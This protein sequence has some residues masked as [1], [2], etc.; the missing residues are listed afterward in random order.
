LQ[1]EYILI[2]GYPGKE[3]LHKH[4]GGGQLTAS[5]LLVEYAAENDLE[6]HVVNTAHTVFPSPTFKEKIVES[7]KRIGTLL[8][9]LKNKNI[10]G[11]IIFSSTG[12]SFYEKI[13]MAWIIEKRKI[14]TLFF[15]RSGH[16]IDLNEQ[17]MV[18]SFINKKLLKIPSYL[19][20]QGTKWIEF[21]KTMD[22]EESKLKLIPNWIRIKYDTT[23]NTND[24]K[25]TFL[26]VGWTVKK[27]GILEVFDVIEE[28][29]DLNDYKFIFAG[30]G[31]LL[32]ELKERKIKNKLDNI[33]M[34][35]WVKPKDLPTL[36]NDSDVFILPSHAEG[37]PNVI[38]EA[39]NYGLPIISTNVGGIADSVID[40]DNGF[41]FEPR[42]KEKLYESIKSLGSSAK[43][44]ET[45]SKNG[46]R[47]L[48][49]RHE[50]YKNCQMIFDS[51]EEKR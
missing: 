2:G 11:V 47:I 22:I 28:H 42:D 40:N 20:A 30:G 51:F 41:I 3:N 34:L 14:K 49:E 36:Y 35:G 45:F 13:V 19:G 44:R 24:E 39:L 12:L 31:T 7:K 8:K 9:L 27:K 18:L 38:L 26:Y 23:Y 46:Q 17:S 4:H 25:V 37:F 10:L 5:T 21:Y 16:F 48:K 33:E 29:D 6:L 50:L 15:I 43:R 32:A 1:K